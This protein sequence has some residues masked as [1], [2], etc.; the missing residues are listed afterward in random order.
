MTFLL[1]FR[2]FYVLVCS[3][4]FA[5]VHQRVEEFLQKSSQIYTGTKQFGRFLTNTYGKTQSEQ[6]NLPNFSAKFG[7]FTKFYQNIKS[8]KY[9]KIENL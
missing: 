1:M 5:F 4:P 7:L 6:P 8:L 3:C 2:A 9:I